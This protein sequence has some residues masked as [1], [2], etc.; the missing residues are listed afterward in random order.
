MLG[1]DPAFLEAL[2][3]VS[4]LAQ[5]DRPALVIGERGTGKELFAHAIHASSQRAGK[6]L[7]PVNC[8]ATPGALANPELSSI[9]RDVDSSVSAHG[10]AL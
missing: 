3:H 7:I 6:P 10:R 4:R 1:S 2:E 5:L 9:L 8:G